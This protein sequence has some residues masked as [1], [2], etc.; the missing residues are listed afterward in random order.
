[1]P[2]VEKQVLERK[3]IVNNIL[4]STYFNV[5]ICLKLRN[6]IKHIYWL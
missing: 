3:H 2:E 5:R 6:L 1:M 4:I